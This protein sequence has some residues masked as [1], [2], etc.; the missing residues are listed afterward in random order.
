MQ[1]Q[2]LHGVN[3][4]GWL[5]PEPWVTP[6]IFAEVGALHE[7]DLVRGL[8]DDVYYHT[9]L[10]HRA[11]FITETDFVSI[12]E[13]GYNAVRL[14]VPWYCYGNISNHKRYVGC[15]ELIDEAVEWAEKTDLNLILSLYINPGAALGSDEIID[16]HLTDIKQVRKAGV[17]VLYA[18]AKRYANR[19]SVYG[20]ELANNPQIRRRKGLSL[21]EGVLLHQLRNYYREAYELIRDAAGPDPVILVPA[22]QDSRVWKRFLASWRDPHMCLALR[23]DASKTKIDVAGPSGLHRYLSELA[24]TIDHVLD[25]SMPCMIT[26]WSASLPISATS[27]T[28]EGKIALER[29]F[30]SEQLRL[31]EQ[32]D[33]WFFT[34]W[35]TEGRLSDWDARIALSS[36]ERAM[37]N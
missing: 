11:V 19:S 1:A 34:S 29:L 9:L 13:R 14:P 20:Y 7:D 18:L 31:Y 21:S 27:M 6:T 26:S 17:E 37:L 33:G 28:P 32:L 23:V 10:K 8:G 5:A 22:G 3:L 36:F 30:T 25:F 15:I 16:R 24:H 35:K 12:K 2:Q 4:A